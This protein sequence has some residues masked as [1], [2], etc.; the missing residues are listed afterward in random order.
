MKAASHFELVIKPVFDHFDYALGRKPKE[1]HALLDAYG[2]GKEYNKKSI[3]IQRSALSRAF[4]E[5]ASQLVENE[6]MS[7]VWQEINPKEIVDK[8]SLSYSKAGGFVVSFH[9]AQ[10]TVG[11]TFKTLRAASDWAVRMGK[12]DKDRANV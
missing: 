7:R 5:G 2:L 9:G 1:R 6:I 12:I 10:Q 11:Q 4:S 3:A 8:A